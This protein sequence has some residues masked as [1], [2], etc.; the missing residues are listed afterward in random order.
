M[1]PFFDF[2][3]GYQLQKIM[4][5]SSSQLASTV[6]SPPSSNGEEAVAQMNNVYGALGAV[7]GYVGA[8]AATVLTFERL[9]W[10]Q[11]FY[12]NFKL[13]SVPSIALLT[14]MSGPLHKVG[15]AVMDKIFQHGL[16]RGSHQ[17]HMLGTVF[18][19]ALGWTYTMHGDDADNPTHT[20]PLR[21]C[22]WARALAYIAMPP[23]NNPDRHGTPDNVEKGNPQ[24]LRARVTV[25][26][27]TI[28]P[29]TPADRASTVRFVSEDTQTPS[30][31][32]FLGV[33]TSELTAIATAIAVFVT[34]RSVWALLWLIPLFI[35]LVSTALAIQ[36]E[37]LIRADETSQSSSDRSFN[38]EIH[39]P[40]ADG[41]FMLITGPS[42][43][44]LQFFRHYGHPKRD[45]FREIVQLAS[46]V[47]FFCVFPLELVISIVWMP[48]DLQYVWLGYQLYVVFAMHVSRFSYFGTSATTEAKIA[49]A[50]S[51]QM[52]GRCT[53]GAERECSILFGHSRDGPETLKVNLSITY[54][55]RYREGQQSLQALLKGGVR[56]H[57]PRA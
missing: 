6:M 10:P 18:F 54:H 44:V 55:N 20:E 48:I 2:L 25:S 19:P 4:A 13:A 39:C 33:I 38:F 41:N 11:R 52:C 1:Q 23:I 29:A 50:F 43:L 56:N 32:V 30:L 3:D 14:P 40:Q 36:R 34:W 53:A 47:L 27:L 42:T 26:H 22:L 5:D 9:L 45:R 57:V 46:I 49:E 28:T 51:R 7:L 24:A 37:Q 15:L 31:R 17:G 16:L 35:R 21:N 8:E 12:S